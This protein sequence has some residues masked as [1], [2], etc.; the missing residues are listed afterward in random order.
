[1]SALKGLFTMLL[2]IAILCAIPFVIELL[3]NAYEVNRNP[4]TMPGAVVADGGPVRPGLNRRQFKE[5]RFRSTGMRI[6]FKAT[7]LPQE[8]ADAI[9]ADVAGR[10]RV[11]QDDREVLAYD[12]RLGPG[13]KKNIGG[14]D[15]QESVGALGIID[16][17]RKYDVECAIVPQLPEDAAAADR[18]HQWEFE[19]GET[20]ELAFTFEGKIPETAGLVFTYSKSPGSLL[21]GTFLER[22]ARRLNRIAR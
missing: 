21:H 5:I 9:E 1:M 3:I 18:L 10:L 15:A 11:L 20:V 8:A 14:L 2:A 4:W 6:Y 7:S 22:I 13:L 16:I 12:F 19:V 17:A